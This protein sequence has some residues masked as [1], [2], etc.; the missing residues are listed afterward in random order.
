M[1]ERVE[2]TGRVP[3]ASRSHTFYQAVENAPLGGPQRPIAP[4]AEK[5][6]DLAP[7]PSDNAMHGEGWS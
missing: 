6:N 3:R 4:P 7:R 2:H 1:D 5:Y